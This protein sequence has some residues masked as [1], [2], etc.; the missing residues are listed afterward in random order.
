MPQR[1]GVEI[2]HG[3]DGSKGLRGWVFGKERGEDFAGKHRGRG[4]LHSLY[5]HRG[6]EEFSPR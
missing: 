6:K 2:S 4:E 5:Y 3:F 1:R